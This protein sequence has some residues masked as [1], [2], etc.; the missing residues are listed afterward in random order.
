MKILLC[1][2]LELAAVSNLDWLLGLARLGSKRL[3]L[4]HHIQTLD[5]SAEDD[6]LT[7]QPD[8]KQ[9]RLDVIRTKINP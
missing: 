6:V 3:D 9:S 1:S 7:V 2:I 8:E 5:D 4:L